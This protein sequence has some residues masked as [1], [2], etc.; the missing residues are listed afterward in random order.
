MTIELGI[1]LALFCALVTNLGFLSST[2]APAPRRTSSSATPGAAPSA[3]FRSKWFAIGMLVAVVAWMLHVGAHG[4]GAAVARPGGHLRRAGLP[5]RARRARVR[6]QRRPAPVGRAWPCTALG[7][8]LLAVTAAR[9]RGATPAT[10]SPAMI[11]FEAGLLGDR[12]VPRLLAPLRRAPRAPRRAARRGRGH[13]L[14]CLRRRHQGA[15]RQRR[16][17]RR[18]W[19]PRVAVAADLPAGLRA[20]LLRVRTRP[21]AAARPCRSSR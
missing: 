14:R 19:R 11:A 6:L 20:G 4:A 7:L 10:R 1:L 17:R 5:D 15:H 21:A 16:L 13:P 3:L 8:A 12:R 18:R 9:A 2:G